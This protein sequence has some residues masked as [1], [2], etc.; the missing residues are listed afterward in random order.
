MSPI[1]FLA[2]T[3]EGYF[4]TKRKKGKKMW[5]FAWRPEWREGILEH[6]KDGHQHYTVA[7]NGRKCHRKYL[8]ADNTWNKLTGWGE[9]GTKQCY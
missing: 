6:L 5:A 3:V 2:F 7:K 8:E 1:L 4:F 9:W